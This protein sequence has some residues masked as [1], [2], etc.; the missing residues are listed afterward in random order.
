MHAMQNKLIAEFADAE[1]AHAYMGSHTVSKLAAQIY[2]TR[3][4]RGWTQAE[5]AE[6]AEMA[7]ERISKI[8][9]G[10][11]TSLTMKTLQKLAVALDVNLRIEFEPFSHG[12]VS[13]CNQSRKL[14]ELPDRVTSLEQL[15][16]SLAV[17]SAPMGLQPILIPQVMD[18]RTTTT[19]VAETRATTVA[20]VVTQWHGKTEATA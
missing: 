12:I 11:F 4:N 18:S 1:Y 14:M 8:E 7:Q 20:P 15:K 10:D 2:W 9:A 5:L 17:I 19:G 3:K 16:H 6:H 13:V